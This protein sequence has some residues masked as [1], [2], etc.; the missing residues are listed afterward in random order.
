MPDYSIVPNPNWVP[1]KVQTQAQVQTVDRG[2]DDND[3]IQ[4]CVGQA[5]PAYPDSCYDRNDLPDND[6]EIDNDNDGL[7]DREGNDE[8]GEDLPQ[9][10]GC[11]GDD[12]FCDADEGCRSESVDCIDDREFDEDD[13]NG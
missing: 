10:G 4:Y 3:D 13:Y 7:D 6:D 8:I 11:Q 5:A 12:N 1:G 9:E 2:D